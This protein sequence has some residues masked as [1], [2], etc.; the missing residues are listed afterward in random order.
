M[1]ELHRGPLPTGHP[2]V[3]ADLHGLPDGH[4]LVRATNNKGEVSTSPLVLLR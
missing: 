2:R 3:Q 1:R 4:Y